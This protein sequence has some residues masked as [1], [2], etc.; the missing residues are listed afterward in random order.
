MASDVASPA[1]KV[2][3]WASSG[4]EAVWL[5]DPPDCGRPCDERLA[6]R[7]D[8]A[9]QISV[10][11]EQTPVTVRFAGTLDEETGINL[12]ALFTELIGEGFADFELQT[13]SLCVPD[14]KGM[15]ALIDLQYQVRKAGSNLAW[16]GITLNHPFTAVMVPKH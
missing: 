7:R 13:S 4:C 16:D 5:G 14:K 9:L 6:W 11:V 12:T 15:R 3:C 1:R 8:V 10:D 2:E